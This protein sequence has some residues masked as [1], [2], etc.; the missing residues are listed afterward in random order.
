[1]PKAHMELPTRT[2]IPMSRPVKGFSIEKQIDNSP[3]LYN[4]LIDT[5]VADDY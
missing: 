4:Y 3:L 2:T 5:S 1:M